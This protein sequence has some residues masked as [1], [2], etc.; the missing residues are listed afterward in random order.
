ML[1]KG[2]DTYIVTGIAHQLVNQF[3]QI[4]QFFIFVTHLVP[5]VA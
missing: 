4:G 2:I 3:F 1:D 5:Q